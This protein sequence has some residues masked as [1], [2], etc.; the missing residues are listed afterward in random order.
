MKN[1]ATKIIRLSIVSSLII[2]INSLQPV[3]GQSGVKIAA[4]PGTADPSAMLDITSSNKGLLFPRVALV[5]LTDNVNPIN[6]PATGLVVY[7]LGTGGVA[8]TGIYFWGGAAWVQLTSGGLSGSGTANQVTKFTGT[9]AIGNSS[10]F[11]DG[12]KVQVASLAGTGLRPVYANG[13]GT[14][15]TNPVATIFS[16]TGGDQSYTVPAGVT[17]ITVKMWGA[18]GGGGFLGGWTMGFSGGAGGFTQ[19][20]I[21]VTGGQVLTV[22]VGGGGVG[23][24]QYN[25]TTTSSYGGG[26]S[27]CNAGGTDCRYGGQ[28]G[29]RSAIRNG[30]TE[31]MTAGGG[32]GGGASRNASISSYGGAGGGL[33]GEDGNNDQYPYGG[34]RGGFQTVGGSSCTAC[35]GNGTAGTQFQ[36]GHAGP[37]SQGYGGGGGGGWFGGGG[38]GYIESNTMAG[39]GGG[40]GYIGG[41]GV[42]NAF[43]ISG[44]YT[45]PPQIW[46]I[47]YATGIGVGGLTITT[48]A[49]GAG[50][51]G[52]VVIIPN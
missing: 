10:I 26:G 4:T 33:I 34:G 46:D 20:T 1:I 6:N 38:G 27:A 50:G 42:S 41:A 13:S 37:T 3:F 43:T 35:T 16:Y 11:D 29:G 31:L 19:G 39:G 2:C 51:N 24:F 28:G 36:G 40:S 5:S 52:R 48:S 9:N 7:N 21:A 30:G 17:S 47:N 15:V 49:A 32:G 25:N 44:H 18:G 22:I 8:A 45:Q 14:L 23:A 12:T